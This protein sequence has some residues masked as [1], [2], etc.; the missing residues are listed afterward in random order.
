MKKDIVIEVVVIFLL[1]AIVATLFAWAIAAEAAVPRV[2]GVVVSCEE[3]RFVKNSGTKPLAAF[4]F[5]KGNTT[6]ALIYHSISE[7]GTQKY[8]VV[9]EYEGVQYTIETSKQ[10]EVG[11][12]IQ[13]KLP[14]K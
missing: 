6:Q 9:V 4:N 14:T 1:G 7:T 3:G 5:A 10:Y 12:A 11:S 2:E 8:N 13:F